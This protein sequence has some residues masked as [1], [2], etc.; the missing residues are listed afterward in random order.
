MRDPDVPDGHDDHE[1]D[2]HDEHEYAYEDWNEPAIPTLP[3]PRP[4]REGE[5]GGTP[6]ALWPLSNPTDSQDD[7]Q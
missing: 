1:H 6:P 7:H 2:E 4:R 3:I 5:T